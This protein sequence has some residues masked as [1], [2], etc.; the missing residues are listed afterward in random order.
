MPETPSGGSVNVNGLRLSYWDWGGSGQ[1]ALL[2]HGL[3]STHHTWDLV[4][5]ILTRDFRVVALDQRGHGESDKPETGYDFATVVSDLN[6]AIQA[7]GLGA[8][9]IAGHS[10]GGN[11]AVEHAATFP[12][13]TKGLCLIDGGAIEVSGYYKSL[14][15]AKVQM[16]PPDFTGMTLDELRDR[17]AQRSWGFEMTPEIREIVFSNF[18]VL[19]DGTI[20]ARLSRQNH[21]RIIEALWDQRPSQIFPQVQSPVMLMP[22]RGGGDRSNAE[23]KERAE[24]DIAAASA[25]L[26][27]SKTVWLE[28][29]VHDVPLQRPGLVA[30]VI[31][32][33][34]KSAF[35]G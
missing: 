31:A 24:K 21:M 4:A 16:A 19:E 29:S 23:W 7:L 26:P 9:I 30:G 2:I 34:Y 27:V 25:G 10:W 12:D 13:E 3:A 17:S 18:E 15:H 1:T 20:R 28:D 32:D 14:D 11:V 6:G 5:P 35:F 8:P 22:T 33:A